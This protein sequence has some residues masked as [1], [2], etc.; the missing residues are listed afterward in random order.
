MA[1]K[2]TVSR[3]VILEAALKMLIRDGYASVNIKSLAAEIGCSTQPIAWHFD[4]MDGLRMALAEYSKEYADRK[5]APKKGNAI[6]GFEYMGESYVKMAL[7]EPNLFKFL[8][9][10][11]SPLG[12]PYELKD[13]S[14]AKDNEEMIKSIA[15]LTGLSFEQIARVIKNTIIYSHGIATMVATGVFKASKKEIMSMIKAASEAFLIKER[16]KNNE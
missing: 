6:E 11:E 1:R 9:L 8:Y 7:N 10:G 13:V 3:E 14:G 15:E 12:K 2:V 16:M 4:N 5:S